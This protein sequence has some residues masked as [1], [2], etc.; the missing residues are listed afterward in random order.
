[1]E[2]KKEHIIYGALGLGLFGALIFGANK[3]F[4]RLKN[5]NILPNGTHSFQK[6][7]GLTNLRLTF[8]QNIR[9]YN[10]NDKSI[11]VKFKQIKV[12]KGDKQIAFTIPTITDF[13][14]PKRG[15]IN[16]NDI[17]VEIPGWSLL[18]MF[19]VAIT[20]LFTDSNAIKNLINQ[21]YF[22][23]I[24]N[25]DGHDF[26]N[27]VKL[28]DETQA[29]P[30]AIGMVASFKRKIYKG[31]KYDFLFPASKGNDITVKK[32][33][34]VQD[35]VK[36]MQQMIPAYANEAKRFAQYIEKKGFTTTL[37]KCQ[38]IWNFIY[39][40]VQYTPDK[41]GIEQLRTPAR[42]WKDRFA[43]V[44]CDCYSNIIGSTLYNLGIPFSFR[45]TKYDHK[46][47]FQH[48]YVIAH[49][50]GKDIIIDCVLDQFNQEKPFTEHEDFKV[51]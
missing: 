23:V 46:N 29:Q 20:T 41:D 3:Y 34:T 15:Q 12:F 33:G 17:V 38:F 47:Y 4:T 25:I 43:G 51:I 26:Q 6:K 35:T 18:E 16:V 22:D 45:I 9:I 7:G 5:V 13:T 2:L 19:G 27:R 10:P 40:T 31:N 30:Q 39:N 44:D 1:M 24:V 49:D 36:V 50:K 8:K 37:E 14:I 42:V 28:S 48:V 32:N 21:I 11:S